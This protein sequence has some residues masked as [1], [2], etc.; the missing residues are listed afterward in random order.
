MLW[1][2]IHGLIFLINPGVSTVITGLLFW[3]FQYFKK[4]KHSFDCLP[5]CQRKAIYR[6]NKETGIGTNPQVKW[7]RCPTPR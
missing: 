4:G 6:L 1:A 7:N 2:K 5:R 3:Y